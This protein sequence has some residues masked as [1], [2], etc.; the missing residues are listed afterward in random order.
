MQPVRRDL[1]RVHPNRIPIQE[2]GPS[3]GVPREISMGIKP[4]VSDQVALAA[5]RVATI[6]RVVGAFFLTQSMC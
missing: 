4:G 2:R 3:G 5:R 6:A 1:I